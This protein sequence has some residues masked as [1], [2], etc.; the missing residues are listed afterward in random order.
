MEGD[1]KGGNGLVGGKHPKLSVIRTSLL[2][3]DN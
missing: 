2:A 3:E 1:T